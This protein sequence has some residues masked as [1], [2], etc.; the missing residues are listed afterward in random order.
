MKKLK[1]LGATLFVGVAMLSLV[2]CGSAIS[3]DYADKINEEAQDGD[4]DYIT[5][6]EVMKKLG[7]NAVDL[8][9]EVLG[10]RGGFIYG[11][12]GCKSWDDI[13]EKIDNGEDVEGLVVTIL[14]GKATLAAYEKITG[15]K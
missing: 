9:A 11:V 5:Y 13:Q 14:N 8:T 2:S 3:Q 1:F 6:D 15:K 7:S 10:V 4:D 12:K